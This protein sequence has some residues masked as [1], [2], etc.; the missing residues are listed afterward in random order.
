MRFLF[1]G[2]AFLLFACSSTAT[3][4]DSGPAGGSLTDGGSDG[5]LDDGGDAGPIDAGPYCPSGYA[6]TPY[7]TAT[8]TTH[9]FSAAT[10]VIDPQTQ[11]VAV[12]ETDVGRMVWSLDTTVAPIASNSLVFL[13]LHHFFDGIAF[14]R[15]ID[16]FVAQGGDPNTL[17]TDRATWGEGGPGYTFANEVN[18]S[19]NFTDA[20]IVAMANSGGD[21]SNGSQFFITFAA[22]PNLDQKYTIFGT[23]T[24]GSAVLPLIARG[25][26][27]M[28]ADPPTTPTRITGLYI[29]EQ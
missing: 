20:G 5:G 13:A 4:P 22:L 15:V 8:A 10:Q 29:C 2:L 24:E 23:V 9:K 7:L 14:H 26:G 12:V 19:V 1:G 3:V 25:T 6:F 17:T 21:D 11:Y 16:G 18:P 27:P 28:Q